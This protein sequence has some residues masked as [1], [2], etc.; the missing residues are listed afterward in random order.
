MKFAHLLL[1]MSFTGAET[2]TTFL[3]VDFHSLPNL[4][5][6]ISV[7]SPQDSTLGASSVRYKQSW[8]LKEPAI[9]VLADSGVVFDLFP[10]EESR[11]WIV[12]PDRSYAIRFLP[13]VD[14]EG[15]PMLEPDSG[16]GLIESDT[17]RQRIILMCGTPCDF[18]A[19]DWVDPHIVLIGG[20]NWDELRPQIYRV[21]VRKGTVDLFYGPQLPMERR[22][23]IA[24]GIQRLWA[25][26]Y[27]WI[28][29]EED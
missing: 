28:D 2:D 19:A 24:A 6:W 11:N 25:D 9:W 13:P 20:G 7:W 4:R 14:E 18:E 5:S 22:Q 29:W 27:P 21:N 17:G 10:I 1:L 3:R 26:T 23:E 15:H 12:S 16:V 8:Q